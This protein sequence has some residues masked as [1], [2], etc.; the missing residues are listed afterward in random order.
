[1]TIEEMIK[2]PGKYE[3]TTP[4]MKVLGLSVMVEVCDDGAVHQLNKQGER[5]GL[6]ARDGWNADCIAERRQ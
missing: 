1:M 4:A 2:A 5:D 6:L 3:V